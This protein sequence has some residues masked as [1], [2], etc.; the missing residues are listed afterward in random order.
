MSVLSA[1]LSAGYAELKQ[2]LYVSR[3]YFFLIMCCLSLML[4][5]SKNR[6]YLMEYQFYGT[7]PRVTAL[8]PELRHYSPSYGTTPRV[9]ALLPELR[10][11]SPGYG[12]TPRV[13][14]LLPEL[15]HYSPSYGTTPRVKALLP[16]LRHYSPS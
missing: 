11:Y 7:T 5:I 9:T 14:A 2:V 4:R 12:T 6:G 16:E 10:H 8:L 3:Q 1:V 15:R 13:T